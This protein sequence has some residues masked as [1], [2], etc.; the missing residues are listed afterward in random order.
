[1]LYVDFTDQIFLENLT[2]NFQLKYFKSYEKFLDYL[3]IKL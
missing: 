2:K 3:I 1:M